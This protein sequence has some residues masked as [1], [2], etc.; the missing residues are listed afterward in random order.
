[1]QSPRLAAITSRI[2]RRGLRTSFRRSS[3]VSSRASTDL[4][5]DEP[6]RGSYPPPSTPEARSPIHTINSIVLRQKSVVDLEDERKAF[7]S[8]LDILEPRPV[9]YWGSLE[10]QLGSLNSL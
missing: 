10:E 2:T 7:A 6:E 1:M 3:S 5:C 4:E 9:V 8:E